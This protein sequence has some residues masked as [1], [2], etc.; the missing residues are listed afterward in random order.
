MI[1]ELKELRNELGKFK[2]FLLYAGIGVCVLIAICLIILD[3]IMENSILPFLLVFTVF[4][5]CVLVIM[6]YY[7]YLVILMGMRQ[8]LKADEC[9]TPEI[10]KQILFETIQEV[11]DHN[12][13]ILERK[14]SQLTILKKKAY[15]TSN[16]FLIRKYLNEKLDFEWKSFELE[17]YTDFLDRNVIDRLILIKAIHEQRKKDLQPKWDFENDIEFM[18]TNLEE[19]NY[20]YDP[21]IQPD[22]REEIRF[23]TKCF[24]SDQ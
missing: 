15:R 21:I 4:W 20:K 24:K 6:L 7:F 18:K 13:D 1:E 5:P 11:R 9:I 12:L 10:S 8:E 16:P 23:D 19:I 14:E 2:L 3:I 17:I 22:E